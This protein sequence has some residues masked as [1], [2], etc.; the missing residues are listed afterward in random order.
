ML[1]ANGHDNNTIT[2]WDI[3]GG[4]QWYECL[5]CGK[6]D[7]VEVETPESI[8]CSGCTCGRPASEHPMQ[9]ERFLGQAHTVDAYRDPFRI[10]PAA[11]EPER[12]PL[13][14]APASHPEHAH[15]AQGDPCA[16]PVA[17]RKLV[18]FLCIDC[19]APIED[20]PAKSYE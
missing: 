8:V 15:V 16:H 6:R 12:H 2:P 4:Y 13:I 9:A 17:M 10:D 11:P 7:R 1:C 3:S 20:L 5:R 18:G 19:G 14:E